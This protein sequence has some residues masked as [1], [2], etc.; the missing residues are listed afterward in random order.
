MNQLFR[1]KYISFLFK[2]HNFVYNIKLLNVR[3]VKCFMLDK[4]K[5]ISK[6]ESQS[7]KTISNMSIIMLSLNITYWKIKTLTENT[8]K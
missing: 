6:Q 4:R 2:K 1:I 8:L 7:A 5:D 3:V